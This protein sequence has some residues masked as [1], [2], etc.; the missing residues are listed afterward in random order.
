MGIWNKPDESKNRTMARFP[1]KEPDVVALALASM[2]TQVAA[3]RQFYKPA[4]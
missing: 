3:G 1:L 4:A 2:T